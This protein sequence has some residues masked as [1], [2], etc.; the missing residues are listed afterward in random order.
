VHAL[1]GRKIV[2]LSAA[3]AIFETPSPGG[4]RQSYRR[5]PDQPGRVLVWE[6]GS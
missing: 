5:K 1:D 3:G 6:L 2:S 4:A